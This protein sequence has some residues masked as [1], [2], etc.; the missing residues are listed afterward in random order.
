MSN[1]FQ[2]FRALDSHARGLFGRA[3]LLLPRIALSLQLRG[4]KKTKESLQEKAHGDA[5][6]QMPDAFTAATVKKTCRMVR[7]GARYGFL[8]P[9]CLVESLTL[10]YMLQKQDI[11]AILRIGVRK[12]SDKFEAH[13]WVEYEG[14]ALNQLEEQHRHYAAFDTGFSDQPGDKP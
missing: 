7:A 10:W 2:R 3:V 11:P 1:A 14:E 5:P 6:Y 8:K 9:T 12:D 4:F 13:A